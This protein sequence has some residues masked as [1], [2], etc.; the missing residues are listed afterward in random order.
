MIFLFE[1][2]GAPLILFI[3]TM[4]R[5]QFPMTLGGLQLKSKK[6]VEK[7]DRPKATYN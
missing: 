6:K 2:E 4:Y 3:Y 5:A 7:N 1:I